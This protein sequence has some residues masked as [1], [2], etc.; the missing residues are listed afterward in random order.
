MITLTQLEYIV[1]V[2]ELG[3]FGKSAQACHV[4]QPTLS[5][6]IAKVEDYYNIKIFDRERTPIAVTEAGQELVK[7]ARHILHGAHHFDHIAKSQGQELQ[8]DYTLGVIPTVAPY[9]LPFFLKNISNTYP[10]V[11]FII[12]ELTT[13]Q[14]LAGLDDGTVDGGILATPLKIAHVIEIPLMTDPFYLYINESETL[15]SKSKITFGDLVQ[16]QVWVLGEGHCFR[17]QMLDICNIKKRHDVLKNVHFESG[18]FETLMGLIDKAGG[19]TLIPELVVRQLDENRKNKTRAFKNPVPS[20]EISLIHTKNQ[21]KKNMTEKFAELIM[22]SLPQDKKVKREKSC[23][24][25]PPIL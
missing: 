15:A 23:H 20:R 10:K 2:A 3:H 17:D 25:V 13:A 9:L 24:V 4:S 19:F 14:I 18:S 16:K 22:K 8:G 6:Q 12:K 7:Q 5:M 1:K 21:Y 11:N